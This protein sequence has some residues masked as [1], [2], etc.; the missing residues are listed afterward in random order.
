MGED[1]GDYLHKSNKAAI[2]ARLAVKTGDLVQFSEVRGGAS[3]LSQNDLRLH[4]GLGA[5]RKMAEVPSA[6]PT[7][8]LRPCT[9]PPTSS[10]PSSKAKAS[11]G[12]QRYRPSPKPDRRHGPEA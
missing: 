1:W 9:T 5:N 12:R 10:I 2:G 11:A 3:Y 6:G 4:F 8:R 7:A